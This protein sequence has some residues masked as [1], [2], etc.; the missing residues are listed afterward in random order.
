LIVIFKFFFFFLDINRFLLQK[1]D[2]AKDFKEKKKILKQLNKKLFKVALPE[3]E[4]SIEENKL[5]SDKNK[6]RQRP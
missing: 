3:S 5:D 6:P 2:Q 4:D 1:F